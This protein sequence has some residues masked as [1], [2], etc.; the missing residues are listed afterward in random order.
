MFHYN[1]LCPVCGAIMDS[2]HATEV[3]GMGESLIGGDG[4]R[5]HGQES[6][7]CKKDDK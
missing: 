5:F 7:E 3:G 4:R 6:P 2:I 1:L